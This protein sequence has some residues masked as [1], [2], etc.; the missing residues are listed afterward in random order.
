[1]MLLLTKKLLLK[2][3]G[4]MLL[5]ICLG[6]H[7]H[8]AENTPQ[9]LLLAQLQVPVETLLTLESVSRETTEISAYEL[10][11]MS[12]TK[13]IH[14]VVADNQQIQIQKTDWMIRQA[15]AEQSR[16]IF[17]PELLTSIER[18][19]HK[20][21]NTVQESLNRNYDSTYSEHNW[22]YDAALQA[23]VPTGGQVK[24]GYNFNELSNSMTRSLSDDKN[25][26]QMYLGISLVQPL[27]KNAGTK[28]TYAGIMSAD[29]ES[30]AAFQDY[31][32]RMMQRVSK[33]SVEYWD[34]YQAQKKLTL[35]DE[36][37]RIAAQ[38]LA[39]NQERYRTGKM[40][41]TEV[42]EAIIGVNTRKTLLS[43]TAHTQMRVANRLRSL[44][45]LTGTD[46]N[47][48]NNL[49]N[50]ETQ[51]EVQPVGAEEIIP[52]KQLDLPIAQGASSPAPPPDPNLNTSPFLLEQLSSNRN[53]IIRSAFELRPEYLAA[54]KKLEQAEIKI[55]FD[56]N[57][58]WPE[59]DLIGSYGLNSL[60]TSTGSSW[61]QIEDGSYSSWSAGLQF[62]LP[63]QG[64]IYSRSQLK[65]SKLEKRRQLMILKE[66]EIELKNRIDTAIDNVMRTTEQ[67]KYARQIIEIQ[68]RLFDTE[69]I[70]L[71]AGQSSSRLVLEKEDDYRLAKE[72]ALSNAIKQQRALVEMEL[73]SGTILQNYG[74]DSMETEL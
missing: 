53:E 34:Y 62:R 32:L 71:E 43:E 47:I 41:E 54:R 13:L 6:T 67:L 52:V 70:R 48:L 19:M 23:L 10:S 20:Q 49:G 8:A 45:A 3:C 25:E 58:R 69:L 60:D 24:L 63:L 65:K 21:R 14:R 40:A 9:P 51:P 68:K 74:V 18:Q 15:E 29:L 16:A 26:Y 7:L 17:E 35:R 33:V 36:S 46:P 27:L 12:L 39:D 44:L 50:R 22:K 61:D 64:D 38:I 57:Q 11:R 1:M 73:A 4:I 59:L 72:D 66:I 28:A 37:Y 5:A 30:L 2:S 55:S 56:E 31:R 42:L